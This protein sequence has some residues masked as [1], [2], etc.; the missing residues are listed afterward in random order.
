MEIRLW[1]F[2][3]PLCLW[4]LEF[5]R[6][7]FALGR[8]VKRVRLLVVGVALSRDQE[9]QV[10]FEQTLTSCWPATRRNLM[11]CI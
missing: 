5:E 1:K 2:A 11:R 6:L 7:V 9:S 10:K 3:L 8:Y 4:G